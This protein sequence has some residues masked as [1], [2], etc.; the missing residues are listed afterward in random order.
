MKT[1]EEFYLPIFQEANIGIIATNKEGQ[2]IISNPY[3]EKLFGYKSKEFLGLKVEN[4][5]PQHIRHQHVRDRLGYYENPRRRSMGAQRELYGLRKDGTTF[6]IE[7]SL[8]YMK[9]Q[10]NTFALAYISDNTIGKNILNELEYQIQQVKS[11]KT[12]LQSLNEE[13]EQKITERTVDLE[14]AVNSLLESKQKLEESEQQLLE[15]LQK[16]RDLNELKSRFVSTASHEFRTPLSTILSSASLISK[17]FKEDQ[18]EKRDK[19]IQRIKSSVQNLT[20]ILNDFLS[21][22][23]IEEGKQKVKTEVVN[24]KECCSDVIDQV[25]GLLKKDQKISFT[26]DQEELFICTD[27]NIVQNILYNLLGNAIKYSTE[28]IELRVIETD[29]EILIEVHDRGI[30]I[31]KEEQKHLFERFFRAS[32]VENLQGTGLGLHIVRRYAQLLGGDIEFESEEKRGSI[33][34]LHLRKDQD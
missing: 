26:A 1:E 34:R 25:S 21:L 11:T 14:Q 24:L 15:S 22:S 31:P 30:G 2:I 16:E 27:R 7:I 12:K 4:L 29:I 9:I 32:N 5:M 8:S 3:C 13:L 23:K 18:Q 17:Y 10:G 33:F 28:A 6:P 20:G 19:H